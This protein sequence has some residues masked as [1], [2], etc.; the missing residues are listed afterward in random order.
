MGAKAQAKRMN[1][2]GAPK[3]EIKAFLVPYRAEALAWQ[4]AQ[5]P[6]Y[7]MRRIMA[8]WLEVPVDYWKLAQLEDYARS[9]S[10][11]K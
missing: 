7:L 6:E 5:D 11:R 1:D 8:W 2:I 3:A 10:A 4:D 9:R